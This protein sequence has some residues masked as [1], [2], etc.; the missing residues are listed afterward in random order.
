MVRRRLGA[1]RWDRHGKADWIQKFNQSLSTVLGL[2]DM[3][4]KSIF[5]ELICLITS[6]LPNKRLVSSDGIPWFI[7]SFIQKTLKRKPH[8]QIDKITFNLSP[9]P[10][11]VIQRTHKELHICTRGACSGTW[12]SVNPARVTQHTHTEVSTQGCQVCWAA[13]RRGAWQITCCPSKDAPYI[14]N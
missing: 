1:L 3:G 11:D 12:I 9:L 7:S 14:L 6:H 10:T 8:C 5:W 4:N 2:I 13:S